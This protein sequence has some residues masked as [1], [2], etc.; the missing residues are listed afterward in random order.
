M[1]ALLRKIVVAATLGTSLLVL[2]PRTTQ[3]DDYWNGY[4]G[5]YDN[6]YRPYYYRRYYAPPSY[7]PQQVPPPPPTYPGTYYYSS[8]NYYA[9]PYYGSGVQ[10]GPL[11]FGW[12]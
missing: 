10:I 12:W 1:N 3:A 8:P 7:Y 5:W 2:P 6:T 9:R 4:W 11:R